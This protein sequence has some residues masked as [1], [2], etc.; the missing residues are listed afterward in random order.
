M[1]II[2]SA[3]CL[4]CSDG[5]LQVE[6]WLA[7]ME[8]WEISHAVIAPTD[9]LVAVYNES[10]NSQVA[11]LV[12]RHSGKLSGLAVANPWYGKRAIGIL[13][14]AF[15]AGLKGLYLHPG[16]QGFHL[17]DYVVDPLIELCAAQ[18]KPIYSYMGTP[19]CCE[20]FQLAELA[21][22]HPRATLIL[23]HMSWSDF[24]G[25]DVIP[26]GGQAPNVLIE[27]SCSG[28]GMVK[29]VASALGAERVLFGSGY[30]R[31]MPSPELSK[32]E[33]ADLDPETRQK[34]LYDNARALWGVRE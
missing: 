13:E 20:P 27:T 14:E 1:P 25:Y 30:P 33:A 32:I 16:R 23:G 5:R 24:C 11:E 2:D 12:A 15:A 17:T 3:V 10:G 7:L 31:S 18:G 4:P 34:I 8:R 28:P 22:R 6:P 19:V 21:R 9:E 29:A 26:A